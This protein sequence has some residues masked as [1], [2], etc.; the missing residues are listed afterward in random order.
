M[1]I[2]CMYVHLHMCAHTIAFMRASEDNLEESGLCSTTWTLE[3][4]LS[5]HRAWHGSESLYPMTHLAS[6]QPVPWF[7]FLLLSH[8]PVR[9][10]QC[11]KNPEHPSCRFGMWFGF[12]SRW[13]S[14]GNYTGTQPELPESALLYNAS[15]RDGRTSQQS[16]AA[17]HDRFSSYCILLKKKTTPWN[18]A[19]LVYCY[20]T[21]TF[22]CGAV[23]CSYIVNSLF[24]FSL[25]MKLRSKPKNFHTR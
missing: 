17:L 24:F 15:T 18:R 4:K 13:E 8:R 23:F 19:K 16:W 12:W 22:S 7:A 20:F 2:Y 3:I 21:L 14:P 25:L 10:V 9:F 1:F 5:G 11:V 6:P